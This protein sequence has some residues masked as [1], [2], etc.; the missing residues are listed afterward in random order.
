MKQINNIVFKED[1]T[2][3]KKYMEVIIHKPCMIATLGIAEVRLSDDETD[4]GEPN[5]WAG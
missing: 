2:P 1:G 4:L 3:V 5:L